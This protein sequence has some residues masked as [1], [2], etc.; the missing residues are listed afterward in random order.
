MTEAR[1]INLV[2]FDVLEDKEEQNTSRKAEKLLQDI[3]FLLN[4]NI[5]GATFS[6]LG[7]LKEG[8]K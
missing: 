7:D 4:M 6:R 5:L 3:H 2:L 1:T 8:K